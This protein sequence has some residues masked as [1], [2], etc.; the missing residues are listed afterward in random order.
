MLVC[1]CAMTQEDVQGTALQIV[2]ERNLRQITD[3]GEIEELCRGIIED[4]QHAKQV[5]RR[6]Q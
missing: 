2:N 6:Y 3:R 5:G 1:F 4:P